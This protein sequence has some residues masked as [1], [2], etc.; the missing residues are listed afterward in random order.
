M[1]PGEGY[2][3]PWCQ[4]VVVQLTANRPL[5]S[6]IRVYALTACLREPVPGKRLPCVASGDQVMQEDLILIAEEPASL[7]DDPQPRT[8]SRWRQIGFTMTP[9]AGTDAYL[10][11]WYRYGGHTPIVYAYLVQ[12]VNSQGGSAMVIADTARTRDKATP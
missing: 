2:K 10:N 8:A 6:M 1:Y 7:A 12:A 3:E 5:D 11:D 4:S 9:P